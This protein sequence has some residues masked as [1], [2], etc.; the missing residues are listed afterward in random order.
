MHGNQ[1]HAPM[2]T[3]ERHRNRTATRFA[4]NPNWNRRGAHTPKEKR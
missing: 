3:A 1:G 2:L 4:M